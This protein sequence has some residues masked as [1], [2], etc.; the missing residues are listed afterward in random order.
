MM[1][2]GKFLRTALGLVFVVAGFVK[3]QDPQ[4][5]A[6]AVENY[7]ILPTAL[8]PGAALGL[9]W[10]ELACGLAL[11]F[12]VLTRGAALIIAVLMAVFLA[13]QGYAVHRGLDIDCGCFG[14]SSGGVDTLSLTR[15]S[16]LLVVALLCLALPHSEQRKRS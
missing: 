3:V 11:V 13:A 14:S 9:A 5:F 16:A 12:G 8:V 15:D 1:G 2:W 4:A 10:L 6:Q 7:R